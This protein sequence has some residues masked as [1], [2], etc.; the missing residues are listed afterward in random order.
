M[1][2]L[3]TL[4]GVSTLKISYNPFQTHIFLFLPYSFGIGRINTFILS[5]SASSKAIPDSRPKWAKFIPFFKPKLCKNHTLWGSTCL[6][7]FS[8]GVPPQ[9]A[10]GSW[11]C[12]LRLIHSKLDALIQFTT[13]V[14]YQKVKWIHD[15]IFQCYIILSALHYIILSA[16]S[17]LRN[18]LDTELLRRHN[19][20]VPEDFSSEEMSPKKAP[21]GQ[22]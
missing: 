4:E 15:N 17:S 6:Y 9:E 14:H 13:I 5:L 20:I 19:L 16:K 10:T 18:C 22:S 12:I 11:C 21:Q 8:K 1:S 7:G 3:L 2:S